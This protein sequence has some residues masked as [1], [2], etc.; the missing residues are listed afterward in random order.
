MQRIWK[1]GGRMVEN[2]ISGNFD[3][4]E[5]EIQ[6][7]KDFLRKEGFIEG[8]DFTKV[9]KYQEADAADIIVYFK[10]GQQLLVEVKEEK[11]ARFS[12]F[13]EYGIDFIS[14][15]Q[16]KNPADA[17][18]WCHP[19]SPNKLKE[20]CDAIVVDKPGKITYSKSDIWL[21]VVKAPDGSYYHLEGYNGM[22]MKMIDFKQYLSENCQF[23]AN[24]K[25]ADQMSSKDKFGSACFYIKPGKMD[26]FRFTKKDWS[27]YRTRVR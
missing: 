1:R 2:T 9:R 20:F 4:T 16:Y 22:K 3:T 6:Y 24:A 19:T 27:T 14:V 26:V 5:I 15:F 21:F 8:V 25:P 7:V 10:N 12:K 17:P 11:Y 13:G 23:T 18:K